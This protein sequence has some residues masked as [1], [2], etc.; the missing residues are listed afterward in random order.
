MV[1]RS[2]RTEN[3]LSGSRL[4]TL[5]AAGLCV[6]LVG[7]GTASAIEVKGP[8]TV[9]NPATLGSDDIIFDGGTLL[10]NGS[11][12][13]EN[14]VGFFG[15]KTNTIA[16]AAGQIIEFGPSF[17]GTFVG[18]DDGRTTIFG[19]ATAT[20][21]ILLN[22]DYASAHPDAHIIVAGGTLGGG[23]AL[24]SLL[25]SA[26]ST[27]VN[28]GATLDFG[29][30]PGYV[31]NLKGS[32]SVIT[33][34]DL[35]LLVDDDSISE[36]SGTISG[37]GSV[38]VLNMGW[39]HAGVIL[40]G[41]NTYTGG[42]YICSCTTLQLGNGGTSGSIVGDVTNGGT[43]AFNRS[44]IYVFTGA[45][46]DDF[47][48]A[49]NVA[50]IGSGTTVLTANHT[51]TGATLVAAGKLIVNGSI[52]DSTTTVFKG[53]TLGGTGTLGD[54]DIFS[55]GTHAPGNSIGTQTVIGPY[56]LSSGANL[57]IEIDP[58][59][60]DRVVVQGTVG[61][62]GSVL[63]VIA[64]SGTYGA[65]TS[66]TII[67]ND[68]AD[69]VTG[70]FGTIRSNFAFY[71][72]SVSYTGGDGNDVVLTFARNAL[73][74]ADVARGPNQTGVANA[75]DQLPGSDPLYLALLNQSAAGAQN[76]YD[77]F[78]G[79]VHASLSGLL[80]QDSHQLRNALL[81][82]LGQAFHAN[83]AAG[84]ALGNGGLVTVA[85]LGSG[86]MAL[87]A[88]SGSEERT[89]VAPVRGSGLAFW[90]LGYGSW[91]DFA[92]DG[93]AGGFDRKLGGFVS[94][95]DVALGGSWRAGLATGYAQS[96]ASFGTRSASAD[97]DSVH[98][99]AYTGGAWGGVSL[100]AG[101]AWTWNEIDT[102]R[103]ITALGLSERAE[104]SYDG[105]TGQIFGE[106]AIPLT[107]GRL[108]Y[109][110]F[111]GLAYVHTDTDGFTETGSTVALRSGGADENVT[112]STLGVRTAVALDNGPYPVTARATF[113]WRHAFDATA[114]GLALSF[115]ATGASFGVHGLPIAED[116]ALIEAG[117]D[118]GLGGGASLGVSYT[119]QISGDA[120]DHG[121]TGSLLWQF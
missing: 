68:D 120:D 65:G 105:N 103:A 20:G 29:S 11:G 38:S 53:A 4:I 66:Y 31:H 54:T 75:L 64:G 81:S 8:V 78:S 21:T 43:L 100:K 113:A 119:G 41:N 69:S 62:T 104:A 27:T 5:T 107:A 33:G 22:T 18:I 87:G 92:S 80:I 2:T 79:D 56:L 37:S 93:T 84:S 55:G 24:T 57:E 58:S 16:A 95:M 96:D 88:G 30:D 121:L 89:P 60:S 108:A 102:V 13:L 86:R 32:G 7:G 116:S 106:A 25:A 101:A 59:S 52:A 12:T 34:G 99:A 115:A 114:P 112:F 14:N 10:F 40:S 118:I 82:R 72:P 23:F 39:S 48:D 63:H 111:A 50:Q 97:V 35:G 47:S 74:F 98:L 109:E 15:G 19:S 36:F 70:T 17:S 49:G 117:L 85:E 71:T 51:Y 91:G 1:S 77:T 61:L 28:A 44:D 46:E 73:T 6:W 42:T 110:P 90:T 26:A 94:G 76:A 3:P 45:I 9:D 83:G 67:D